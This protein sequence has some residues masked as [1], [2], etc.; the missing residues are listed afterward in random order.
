M[1]RTWRLFYT[2]SHGVESFPRRRGSFCSSM[3]GSV[4][5]IWS[6]QTKQERGFSRIRSSQICNSKGIH[7]ALGF[8]PFASTS[9]SVAEFKNL[10]WQKCMYHT[11]QSKGK[12]NCTAFC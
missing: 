1:A 11:Q 8:T 3:R 10:L 12:T 5:W 7:Y 2:T 6:T 4:L 9:P